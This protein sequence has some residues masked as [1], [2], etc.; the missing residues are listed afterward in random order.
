MKYL[1]ICSGIEAASVAW[2]SLSWEPVGF[3]EVEPFCKA[4]L[5][6]Y[7]PEVHNYG[8]FTRIERIPAADLCVAGTPCQDF[9]VA[10]LRGSLAGARGILTLQW[11]ALVERAR[12]RWLVW[13]NVPGIFSA[14]Q[15]RAF[16]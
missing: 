9:S 14:D 1:S 6:H 4:L 2:H 10:G 16:G 12:F 11:L 15:G 7:W 5:K 3:A 13:E 8:D